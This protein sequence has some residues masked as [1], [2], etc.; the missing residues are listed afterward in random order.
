VCRTTNS[1]TSSLI[2]FIASSSNVLAASFQINESIARHGK[3][4]SD[5]KFLYEHG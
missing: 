4:T 3:A 5:G 1:T 2:K